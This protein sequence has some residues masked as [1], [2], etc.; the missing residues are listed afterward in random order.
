ME[1]LMAEWKDY[2]VA[3]LHK[4]LEGTQLYR[5]V[6]EEV[7]DL[8]NM[9]METPDKLHLFIVGIFGDCDGPTARFITSMM[10]YCGPFLAQ[11][12]PRKA[13]REYF[14][15]SDSASR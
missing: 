11:N 7:L 10:V 5:K 13:A 4:D 3:G 12:N 1:D 8:F 6:M 15:K 2:V 9:V 14:V